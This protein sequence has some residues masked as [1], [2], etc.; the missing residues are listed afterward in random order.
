M[1]ENE[2]K[3][4]LNIYS[5]YIEMC[6]NTTIDVFIAKRALAI[7]MME[8]ES[9][10]S[11]TEYREIVNH[12]LE[13]YPDQKPRLFLAGHVIED[14]PKLLEEVKEK[15]NEECEECEKD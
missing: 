10:V 14:I 3:N 6:M 4:I 2:Y 5:N 7:I 12:I 8:I 15:R 11:H 13:K 9:R 1:T